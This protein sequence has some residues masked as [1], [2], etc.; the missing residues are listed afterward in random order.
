MKYNYCMAVSYYGNPI[1]VVLW[2]I[3]DSSTL[4]CLRVSAVYTGAGW[5]SRVEVVL[6]GDGAGGG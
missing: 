1:S 2:V 5:I 6:G 4:P 3:Q